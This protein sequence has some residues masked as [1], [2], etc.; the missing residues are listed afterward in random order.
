MRKYTVVNGT[1]NAY[2]IGFSDFI[3]MNNVADATVSRSRKSEVIVFDAS[4][5][6]HGT[7]DFAAARTLVQGFYNANSILPYKPADNV[8]FYSEATDGQYYPYIWA[9]PTAVDLESGN[10]RFWSVS[11]GFE[12]TQNVV[13]RRGKGL[14]FRVQV[15]AP[16][17]SGWAKIARVEEWTLNGATVEL[18]AANIK[19][20]YIIDTLLPLPNKANG[21]P[22]LYSSEAR[23]NETDF[24]GVLGTIRVIGQEL[25]AMRSGGTFDA[26]WGVSTSN[27]ELPPLLSLDGLYDA[28]NKLDL[29]SRTATRKVNGIVTIQMQRTSGNYRLDVTTNYIQST[30]TDVSYLEPTVTEDYKLYEIKGE[31]FPFDP[32]TFDANEWLCALSLYS[33]DFGAAYDG[34]HLEGNVTP[35]TSISDTLRSDRTYDW[36]IDGGNAYPINTTHGAFQSYP[37]VWLVSDAQTG[38]PT[39]IMKVNERTG[40]TRAGADNTFYGVRFALGNIKDWID[41]TA[42]AAETRQWRLAI[43]FTLTKPTEA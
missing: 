38:I 40:K 4:A 27:R 17:G 18:S 31:T 8:A 19:P 39:E 6:Y 11:N 34:W 20:I 1:G 43:N 16:A 32:A 29:R 9:R 26:E 2:T 36:G 41:Q 33:I 35:L 30:N 13:T 15:G 25:D 12:I 21:A 3:M 10:R 42:I 37:Q 7:C 24:G 28:V 5:S 23:Y 22:L 14:E